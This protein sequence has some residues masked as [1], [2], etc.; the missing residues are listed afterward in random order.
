MH[1]TNTTCTHRESLQWTVWQHIQSTHTACVYITCTNYTMHPAIHSLHSMHKVWVT[2]M[3]S[4]QSSRRMCYTG[5]M[6]HCITSLI[7]TRWYIYIPPWAPTSL[8]MHLF[9]YTHTTVRHRTGTVWRADI[10][11][12]VWEEPV[13][14]T[15]VF[16]EVA[17]WDTCSSQRQ[18]AMAVSV[19]WSNHK[20]THMTQ[21]DWITCPY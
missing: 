11:S 9:Q 18:V 6:L 14:M 7:C 5:C 16:R 20:C 21:T 12:I 4:A 10:D 8:T 1:T 3:F 2:C 15:M 13:C 17:V 19:C